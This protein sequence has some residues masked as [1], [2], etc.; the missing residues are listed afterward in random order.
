MSSYAV[1]ET[2]VVIL[3]GLVSAYQVM[4]VLMPRATQRLRAVIATR[5][6]ARRGGGGRSLATRLNDAGAVSGCAIGCGSGCNGCIAAAGSNQPPVERQE[7][8]R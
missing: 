3:I 6:H 1:V 5:V 2:V 4:R 8:S 7:P